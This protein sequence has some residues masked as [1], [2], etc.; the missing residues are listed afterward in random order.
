MS[1]AKR[2][3][4]LEALGIDVWISR[5]AAPVRD[6]LLIG[7]GRGSTLLVCESPAASSGKLADDIVRALGVEPVWAW[8]DPDGG[9]GSEKLDEAIATRL[10]TRVIVF[11]TEPASQI[12]GAKVPSVLG[13]AAITLVSSLDELAVSG[14]KKQTFWALTRSINEDLSPTAAE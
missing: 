14:S 8:L 9:P 7:P 2:R 10:L 4:Y 1:E 11:G 6:R 3:D 13:S 5:P 12:F